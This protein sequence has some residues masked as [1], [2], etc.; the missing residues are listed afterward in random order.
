MGDFILTLLHSATNTHILHWQTKSFAEH[1]ALGE[2]YEAMPGLIDDLV[3]ATQGALGE[4]LE[5]P[6][7]YYAPAKD[8][9]TELEDLRDY[10]VE[11]RHVM[12]ASSEIQNLLDNI[13]DQIDSTLYKLKF[14]R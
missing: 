12:P 9:L 7:H 14:L 3:E 11:N 13:G 2:F 1:M 8:G 5:F 4:I 6:S 10:F